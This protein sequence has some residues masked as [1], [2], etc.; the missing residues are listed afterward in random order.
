[1]ASWDPFADG[2]LITERFGGRF[3]LGWPDDVLL[4]DDDGA[5]TPAADVFEDREGWCL[6]VELPGVRARDLAVTVSSD[7][8]VVEAERT[9]SHA[10]GRRVHALEGRYGRMR[11][12][13]LLPVRSEPDKA[14]AE[15]RGG[16]LRV[17]VPR[18]AATA[19]TSRTLELVDEPP[20]D[21]PVDD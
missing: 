21:I 8:V 4:A 7:T 11:R 15:L 5:L 6:E 20:R 1:M 14:L 3:K 17:F 9:F 2:F 10:N 19:T 13:F 18:V 16:V 12:E